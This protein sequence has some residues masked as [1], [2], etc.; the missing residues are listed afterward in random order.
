VLGIVRYIGPVD[1]E[2]GTFIGLEM[3]SGGDIISG[4]DNYC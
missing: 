3:E 4:K 1:G 2:D